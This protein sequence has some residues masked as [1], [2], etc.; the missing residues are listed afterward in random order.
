[1]ISVVD[2][3][4]ADYAGSGKTVGYSVPLEFE[5]VVVASEE[6]GKREGDGR[7]AR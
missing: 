1:M 6:I 3:R 2:V 4:S 7:L 5:Q